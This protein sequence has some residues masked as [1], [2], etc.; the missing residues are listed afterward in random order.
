V[1]T[2]I[3]C[4]LILLQSDGFFYGTAIVGMCYGEMM[5][6]KIEM[7]SSFCIF[8]LVYIFVI[9]KIV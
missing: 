1:H 2:L 5:T 9:M 4:W 6:V 7:C 8:L 3:M